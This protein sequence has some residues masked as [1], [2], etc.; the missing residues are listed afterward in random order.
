MHLNSIRMVGFKRYL[1]TTIEFGPGLNIFYGPNEAG[2]STLHQA[3]ITGLYGLSRRSD[4]N[5][6]RTREEA[7]SW[8]EVP[9]CLIELDY[10]ADGSRFLLNRDMLSGKVELYEMGSSGGRSLLT[11]NREEIDAAIVRQTGVEDAY[12]FNRTVSVCQADLAEAADMERIGS[13]IESMFAGADA[14]T[15]TDAAEFLD[16]NVRKPLRK[17]RNESPGRLDKLTERLET[18]ITEIERARGE[19]RRREELGEKIENLERRLPVKDSRLRELTELLHKSEAKRKIDEELESRQTQ[20]HGLQERIRKIEEC[21][22]KLQELQEA[23]RDMGTLT[24]FDPDQLDSARTELERARADL[25]AKASACAAR[26]QSMQKRLKAAEEISAEIALIQQQIDEFGKLA[27]EEELD[28]LDG[29]RRELADKVRAAAEHVQ[30]QEERLERIKHSLWGLEQFASKYPELGDAW[31]LQSEWQRLELRKDEHKRA[32][33]HARLALASHEEHRPPPTFG[34]L[35][36]EMPLPAAA[37]ALML[38]AV[39]TAHGYLRFVLLGVA[40]AVGA[41]WTVWKT[42]RRSR[43]EQWRADHKRLQNEVSEAESRWREICD[44]IAEFTQKIGVNEENVSS[45]ISEYRSNQEDLRS[46]RRENEQCLKDLEHSRNARDEAEKESR[47]LAETYNCGSIPVLRDRISQVRNLRRE[48][49][50][51][52][53]RLAG[54]LGLEKL[55]EREEMLLSAREILAELNDQKHRIEKEQMDHAH[56]ESEFLQRTSCDDILQLAERT[57]RLRALLSEK[58]KLTASMD[59][60]AAGKTL[61]Q[62]INDQNALTLE[63]KVARTR[64]EQ[65]FSGF[66][67]TAEQHEFWR[68]EKERLENELPQLSTDLTAARTELTL[69]EEHASTSPAELE[70]EKAFIEAEIERGDFTVTACN[71]AMAVL[72]EVDREHHDIYVPKLEQESGRHFNKLTGGAYATVNL[73]DKWPRGLM[74][75]DT[76][77]RMVD[78]DKLSRGTVDQLYF[79]LRLALAGALSGRTAIPMILDDPF[80]NFD[81]D[82][83]EQ[84]LNTIAGLAADGRQVLYFTHSPHAATREQQ[85]RQQGISVNCVRLGN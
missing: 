64:L 53:E 28:V 67:P 65:D 57:R 25:E 14:I 77:G 31:R 60:H 62:L 19:D 1:D 78:A 13:N 82:R 50:K 40:V 47:R 85:W 42:K 23:L 55:G 80:V 22:R 76:T 79:S 46:L 17:V 72:R 11:A 10:E 36:K 69:L 29:H 24:L 8:Q 48:I 7:R 81:A 2:K 12:V 68:K 32:L 34:H 84:A 41:W 33:D 21:E 30:E 59:A 71:Y 58:E 5:L 73:A 83:L 35:L 6:L 4:A 27:A 16:K 74:A 38:A 37:L 26:I 75:V 49:D 3:I 51:L 56:R 61:D 44:A 54:V 15:A 45:F 70:G 43:R 20:F 52:S 66:E 18:L 39:T 9:E 63:I